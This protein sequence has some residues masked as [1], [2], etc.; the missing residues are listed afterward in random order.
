MGD[1]KYLLINGKSRQVQVEDA[2]YEKGILVS[3][4][5]LK[6]AKTDLDGKEVP[7][8]AEDANAI[9]RKIYIDFFKKP[10]KNI[11]VLS[12]AGS[13]MDVGGPSMVELWEKAENMYKDGPID[14]FKVIRESVNYNSTTINLE[15]LLSQIDGFGKYN[16]N[17]SIKIGENEKSYQLSKMKF[18]SL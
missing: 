9:K 4:S 17:T 12:G 1:W 8:T 5:G 10:F 15:A 11:L 3:I 7:P 6:P 2:K 16:R 13:S 14:G 18:S